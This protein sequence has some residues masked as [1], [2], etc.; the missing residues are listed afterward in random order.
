MKGKAMDNKSAKEGVFYWLFWTL[1]L[2]DYVLEKFG[3]EATNQ[4]EVKREELFQLGDSAN[5]SAG[6]PTV[7]EPP[8]KCS[9]C[10]FEHHAR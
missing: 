6:V 9:S 5:D 7:V 1:N 8:Y 10:G 2:T 4:E 3:S